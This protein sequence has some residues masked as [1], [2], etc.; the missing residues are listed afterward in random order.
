MN[1]IYSTFVQYIQLVSFTNCISDKSN[2][3]ETDGKDNAELV[4]ETNA[5]ASFGGNSSEILND[6]SNNY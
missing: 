5:K 1:I 6:Q 2:S 3:S 4:V